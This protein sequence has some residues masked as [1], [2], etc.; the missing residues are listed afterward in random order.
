MGF[1]FYGCFLCNPSA[2]KL[3]GKWRSPTFENKLWCSNLLQFFVLSPFRPVVLFA[4]S[5]F[6]MIILFPHKHRYHAGWIGAGASPSTRW[7]QMM[8]DATWENDRLPWRAALRKVSLDTCWLRGTKNNNACTF[9]KS[10][11]LR[12]SSRGALELKVLF[13]WLEKQCFSTRNPTQ[14]LLKN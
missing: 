3:L 9:A 8:F 12:N 5:W 1:C 2:T 13:H 11:F 6:G 7:R 14:Q 10:P 4:T